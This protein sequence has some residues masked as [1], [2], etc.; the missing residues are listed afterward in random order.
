MPVAAN[1]EAGPRRPNSF[2]GELRGRKNKNTIKEK[3]AAPN[4]GAPSSPE[5]LY[6]PYYE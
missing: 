2:R 6:V 5:K 1:W 3:R 4:R